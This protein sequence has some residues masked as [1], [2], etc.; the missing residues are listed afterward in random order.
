MLEEHRAPI[1]L[2]VTVRVLENQ[3]AVVA[4]ENVLELFGCGLGTVRVPPH[5]VPLPL[6]GGEGARRAGQGVHVLGWFSV[7][8]RVSESFSDPETPA[9]VNGEGNGLLNVRLTG[10]EGRFESGGRRHY[11]RSLIRRLAA[12]LQI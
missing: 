12:V 6:R 4:A 10:E 3:D 5:P 7:A 8:D 11:L 9:M 2:A 1:E